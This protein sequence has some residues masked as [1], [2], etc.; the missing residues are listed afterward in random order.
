MVRSKSGSNIYL[1]CQGALLSRKTAKARKGAGNSLD[2]LEI[3]FFE[4]N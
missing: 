3:I 2:S 4:S 1:Q